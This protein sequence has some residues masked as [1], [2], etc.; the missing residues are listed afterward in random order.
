MTS[1]VI[2]GADGELGQALAAAAFSRGFKVR[3][4]TRR[5]PSARELGWSTVR[6]DLLDCPSPEALLDGCEVLL[7]PFGQSDGEHLDFYVDLHMSSVV[8]SL[9]EELEERGVDLVLVGRGPH[10]LPTCRIS[11][12]RDG[13]QLLA[14]RA[15]LLFYA[16]HTGLQWTYI[17]PGRL[18]GSTEVRRTPTCLVEAFDSGS[19]IG[20]GVGSM[21]DYTRSVVDYVERSMPSAAQARQ[22]AQ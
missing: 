1:V 5:P 17:S 2:A 13:A 12:S 19:A 11:E 3:A 18:L 21:T 7:V 9:A 15:A 4:T 8:G 14:E 16:M 22:G 6:G 10:A 20:G